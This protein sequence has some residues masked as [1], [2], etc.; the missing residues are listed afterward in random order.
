[1]GIV[2]EYSFEDVHILNKT[3][4]NINKFKDSE[5]I[6]VIPGFYGYNQEGN[7]LTFSRGGSD[8]TGAIVARGDFMRYL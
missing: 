3:Y 1:M 5:D 7:R 6:L 2:L 8:I 4:E